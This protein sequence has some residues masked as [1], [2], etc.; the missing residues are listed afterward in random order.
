MKYKFFRFGK[1]TIVYGLESGIATMTMVPSDMTERLCEEKMNG[2][3]PFGRVRPEPAMQIAVEGDD[4]PRE[5]SAG[6][7]FRNKALSKRWGLPKFE[8]TENEAGRNLT[9]AY[10]SGEGLVARQIFV[11]RPGDEAIS[12]YC[13]VKNETAGSIVLECVPSFFLSRL[14]PFVK[15]NDQADLVI[16]RMRNYWSAEGML[17]SGAPSEYGLEDP[18]S[19]LGVRVEKIGQVGTMPANGWLPWAAVEDKTNGC[20]WAVQLEAPASW[21]IEIA[22]AYNG[23]SLGG[24]LADFAYGHWKKNLAVG[25]TFRTHR[26]FLTACRGNFMKAAANLV[27]LQENGMDVPLSEKSLPVLY[28]EYCYTWG[29]PSLE[30]VR[31]LLPVCQRFGFKYFVVDA[32]WYSEEGKDWNSL[33]DWNVNRRLFPGGLKEYAD[34]CGEYGLTAGIWFEF[35]SVSFDSAVA[36]EHPDW[37]LTYENKPI[38]HEKRC[39]LDFRKKAVREYAHEKVTKL[40]LSTG[41]RYI[42]IDY[43]ETVGLGVDGA[44]SLGEGLRRHVEEALGFYRSLREEIP[45]LVVE[46]CS[47]G[48]MRH[49]P[50]WLSMGSMC[51]FSDAHEGPEGA[52]IACNLHRFIPARKMQIWATIK[53]DYDKDDACF[54]MAKS[55]L[56]RM[57]ISG[58]LSDKSEAVLETVRGGVEFYDRIKDVIRDGET[59]GIGQKGI[60]YLRELHGVQTLTR[61]S[62]DERRMLWYCFIVGRPGET[63]TETIPRGYRPVSVYGNAEVFLENVQISAVAAE[64]DMVGCVVLLEKSG[65]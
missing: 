36:K 39:M 29:K 16:H 48:G 21:Q 45:D 53:D 61:L 4:Y 19:G 40:L 59:I 50:L 14:T 56:G 34:L 44:E 12:T 47:S 60:T 55:M 24:G 26:A 57:C 37:L 46:I 41:I 13:E 58:N 20:A 52:V 65:N 31:K 62:K 15:F 28:N 64:A 5:F 42:K 11:Q 9:A 18:W 22:S 1:T 10:R 27:R 49:E 23:I 3:D 35:E 30:I 32:G 7:T 54:T 33:G 51:S 43:N 2:K 25:E 8:F 63:V 6:K 38:A 17:V